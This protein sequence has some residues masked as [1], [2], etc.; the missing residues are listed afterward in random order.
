MLS[1]CYGCAH[2]NAGNP[3][4]ALALPANSSS[5]TI[6]STK[7][8]F[9]EYSQD[10]PYPGDGIVEVPPNSNL[11]YVLVELWLPDAQH[12]MASTILNSFA[13]TG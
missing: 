10:D 2:D 13:M 7:V 6:S 1:G 12:G 8:G 9:R 3:A 11:G 4:P 5:F